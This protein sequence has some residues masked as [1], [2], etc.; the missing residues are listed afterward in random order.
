EISGFEL[1]AR[2]A[3]VEL[4]VELEDRAALDSLRVFGVGGEMDMEY[5][6]VY[7]SRRDS[8]AD[9][10]GR[11]RASYPARTVQREKGIYT[12][13]VRI[14]DGGEE[15]TAGAAAGTPLSTREGERITLRLEACGLGPRSVM[16]RGVS[17][18]VARAGSGVEAH[19]AEGEGSGPR[20]QWAEGL[21]RMYG[22]LPT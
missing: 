9:G 7:D 4:D 20:W 8:I 2:V 19:G 12:L 13:S 15:G 5:S 18:Y 22:V 3:R 1:G 11:D 10:R 14:Q 6:S 16:G 21:D 17:V